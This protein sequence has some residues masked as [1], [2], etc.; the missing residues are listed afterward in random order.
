MHCLVRICTGRRKDHG[1]DVSPPGVDTSQNIN[2]LN[3][4]SEEANKSLDHGTD[5]L[6]FCPNWQ[7]AQLFKEWQK[8]ARMCFKGGLAPLSFHIYG[9]LILVPGDVQ[10]TQTDCSKTIKTPIVIHTKSNGCPKVPAITST[11]GYKTKVIQAM[12][13]DYC[14][15]HIRES[16][17]DYLW[18]L[19]T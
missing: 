5:F 6:K 17:D 3:I 11:D 2:A 4:C 15:T 9:D 16:S 12:L 8:Y 19:V 18:S 14:T 7:N 10:T 1:W 13:R